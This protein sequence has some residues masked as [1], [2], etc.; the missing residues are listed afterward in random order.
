LLRLNRAAQQSGVELRQSYT[1]TA[2]R[3]AVQ[4]GR[5]AHAQQ[6]RRMHRK[7]K[8]LKGRLGRV[9]RDLERKTSAWDVVPGGCQAFCRV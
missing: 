8:K 5:Y 6:Y 2:K 9:V 3:T 4:I 7:L 1:C